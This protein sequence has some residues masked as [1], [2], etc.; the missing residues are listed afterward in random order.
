VH[1]HVQQHRHFSEYAFYE[2]L[3]GECTNHPLLIS[4]PLSSALDHLTFVCVCECVCV[5]D[6]SLNSGLR[7][8]KAGALDHFALVILEMVFHELFA[9][10]GLEPQFS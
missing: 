5:C 6:W 1:H 3:S 7:A 4:N 2:D 8:C 9:Q 10:A